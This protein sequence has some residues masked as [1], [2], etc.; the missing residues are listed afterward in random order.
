M[1]AGFR[2]GICPALLV[3]N[4]IKEQF[5]LQD[6]DSASE[7][8]IRLLGS[9]YPV[10][11]DGVVVKPPIS[12]NVPAGLRNNK[13]TESDGDWFPKNAIARGRKSCV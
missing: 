10:R 1:D 11:L 4:S 9:D 6:E 8:D 13:R 12:K 5:G 7:F 3:Q 2:D